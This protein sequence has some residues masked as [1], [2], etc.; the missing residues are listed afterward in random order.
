MKNKTVLVLLVALSATVFVFTGCGKKEADTEPVVS[1]AVETIETTEESEPET[2]EIE[3]SAEVET[4]P[5]ESTEE[6]VETDSV[7]GTTLTQ[8][9]IDEYNATHSMKYNAE[10]KTVTSSNSGRVYEA[11]GQPGDSW[12]RMDEAT[13][14]EIL[15]KGDPTGKTEDY[16]SMEEYYKARDEYFAA[17]AE[18]NGFDG[19]DL[20]G[21]WYYDYYAW[22]EA[23]DALAA[24][25]PQIEKDILDQHG[26]Q[27][28]YVPGFVW[29][30]E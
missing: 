9:E 27:E 15:A 24:Q 4:E 22:K 1:E 16:A 26:Y 28:D 10:D 5:V 19:S 21:K 8:E 29:A 3:E 30:D 23:S 11:V 18:I 12:H 20:G 7:E 13:A 14:K 2:A 17:D 6:V 25:R